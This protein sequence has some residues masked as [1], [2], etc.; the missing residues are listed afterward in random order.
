MALALAGICAASA[1]AAS[2]HRADAPASVPIELVVR[3]AES[4][5]PLSAHVRLEGPSSALRLV[6][7]SPGG[8]GEVELA[9]GRWAVAVSA[10]EHWPLTATLVAGETAPRT[11]AFELD[12]VV[13]SPESIPPEPV[14]GVALLAGRVCSAESGDPLAGVT[15]AVVG[16][17]STTTD[18]D[19]RYELYLPARA[20][21][22][23]ARPLVEAAIVTLE[24]SLAGHATRRLTDVLAAEGS[25]FHRWRLASGSGIEIAQDAHRLQGTTGG[26]GAPRAATGE[27]SS[28]ARPEGSGLVLPPPVSVRV[29]FAD[30][31][32]SVPCCTNSCTAVCVLPL[33]TYVARGLNDEW[34]ASWQSDSL[35]S[36]AIAY[37]SYAA[38]RVDH[39]IRSTFDICS[40]ACCQVNDPDTA[41]STNAAV[42]ATAGLLLERNGEAFAAE[43]SAENN[44]WDDPGDGLTCSNADLSCGD[45][46]VGSPALGWPCLADSVALGHGCF[47]HGRGL[48]QWGSQRWSQ[49]GATWRWILDH[50]YNANGNP[51]GL[52]SAWLASPL[53]AGPGSHCPDAAAAGDRIALH[54]RP[55]LHAAAPLPGVLF[56]ASVRPTGGGAWRSDPANDAP[57]ALTPGTNLAT[58][59]FDLPGDL[60]AGL[61]DVAL[62]LWLDVDSDGAITAADLPLDQRQLTAA[63]R[64]EA[65]VD[66]LFADCFESGDTVRW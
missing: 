50:Y 33:E 58:R 12:P 29:G 54:L 24:A 15:V 44:A 48:S 35:R 61:Y 21:S 19:G 4:G 3:S 59:E 41:A 2:E 25:L 57:V 63:L 42:A 52:R 53:A 1:A 5:A 14:P 10:P 17:P 56:G 16:G 13:R 65:G 20:L 27:G 32:C 34:I 51:E 64:I 26:V 37:R 36:G 47:G 40:S 9:A 55:E 43:Y 22:G 62:A 49:S 38:W 45:G 66:L 8:R 23:P 60:G 30:A 28:G 7:L 31:G 18:L 39:P 6:D 46:W 11:W